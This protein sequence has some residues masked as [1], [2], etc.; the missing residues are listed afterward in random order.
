MSRSIRC[1]SV[2]IRTA[3]A[4]LGSLLLFGASPAVGAAT[5]GPLMLVSG[6]SPFA[7]CPDTLGWPSP[8]ITYTNAEVEPFLAVNPK[9]QNNMIGV[10]QEDRFGAGGGAHGLIAVTSLDGGATWTR[11]LPRFGKCAGGTAANGDDYDRNSDPWVSIGGDGI[12]YFAGGGAAAALTITGVL[13]STSTDGG[14]HWSEPVTIQRDNSPDYSIFNDKPAVTADP[15]KPRTAYVV[16]ERSPTDHPYLSMTTDGGKSWSAGRDLTPQEDNLHTVG[17]IIAVLPHDGNHGPR[18]LV[19]V[20]HYA[21]GSFAPDDSF[22]GL[23]RSIDGGKT[24]SGPI[25][26]THKVDV[27]DVDPDTGHPLRTGAEFG[28]LPSV[29]VDPGSGTLYVVWADSRFSRGTHNDIALSKSTDGGLTWST[30]VKVNQSPPGVTAFTPSV[31]VLPDGTVGVSYYDLRNNTPDPTTLLTDYFLA[32]SDDGGKRWRETQITPTSFDDTT[33]P[34]TPSGFFL[35]DYQG[36]A[37][38]RD[39]FKPL[40][41]QTNSGNLDNR[42]DVWRVR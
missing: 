39:S 4:V 37:N 12:A 26:I 25:T 16:W 20:F 3:V 14:L 22:I 1:N 2:V 40:F 28:G 11:S 6:P 15:V 9:D 8:S 36:L 41:I 42:T 7:S 31:D 19:D 33:A 18:T 5:V 30:P 10:Y 23:V 27:I 32:R 24:W 21:K 13:A 38:D 34:D 29:A 17:N 35:G